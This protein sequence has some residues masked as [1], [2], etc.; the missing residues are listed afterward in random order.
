MVLTFCVV[1]E[2]NV[3][4]NYCISHD[5]WTYAEERLKELLKR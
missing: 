3:A 4:M 5:A 1:E 2:L